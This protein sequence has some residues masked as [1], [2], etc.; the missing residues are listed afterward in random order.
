MC[1]RSLN[2]QNCAV[3]SIR[4]TRFCRRSLRPSTQFFCWTSD[5]TRP[6]T[7]PE[8]IQMTSLEISHRV[9]LPV[10]LCVCLSVCVCLFLRLLFRV[11][12]CHR[13][14]NF[15][16]ITSAKEF[17]FLSACVCLSVY[18]FASHEI[19]QKLLNRF[20]QNLA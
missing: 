1:D 3:C 11:R 4:Y 6:W 8:C 13:C 14:Y 17:M 15:T 19:T 7:D 12:R 20:S 18:L 5:L 16:L 10:C 9:C 2:V